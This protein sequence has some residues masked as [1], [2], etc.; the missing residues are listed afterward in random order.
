[1]AEEVVR[2]VELQGRMPW[3]TALRGYV[4]SRLI[5]SELPGRNELGAE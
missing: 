5:R 2:D 4:D 3:I 1:M